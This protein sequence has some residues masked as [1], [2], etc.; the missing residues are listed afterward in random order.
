[1]QNAYWGLVVICEN[2]LNRRARRKKVNF[3]KKE[4]KGF[5]TKKRL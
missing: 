4:R 1:M 2:R 5:V 3:G